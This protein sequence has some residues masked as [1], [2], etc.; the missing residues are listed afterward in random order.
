MLFRSA[1]LPGLQHVTGP[2]T[3]IQESHV[4]NDIMHM[5]D[6]LQHGTAP[7]PTA[8]H[9]RHVVEVIERAY[10]AARTGQTQDVTST[11]ERIV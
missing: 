8:E 11:F 10:I 9:A 7:V 4:Y 5:V 1:S 6:C 3:T 2:H